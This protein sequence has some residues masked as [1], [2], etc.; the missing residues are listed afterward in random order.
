MTKWSE[1]R[2]FNSIWK[3]EKLVPGRRA[4]DV[5]FK[6]YATYMDIKLI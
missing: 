2:S 4:D 1:Q 6:K 5:Q 3:R